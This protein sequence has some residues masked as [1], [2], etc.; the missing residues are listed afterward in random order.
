MKRRTRRL[1]VDRSNEYPEDGIKYLIEKMVMISDGDVINNNKEELLL[2]RDMR[3]SALILVLADTG[4]RVD[5][6]CRLKTGDID[7]NERQAIITSIGKKQNFIIRFSTRSIVAVRKYLHLRHPLDIG[8]GYKLSTLP[9]F[10]RHDR[11]LAGTKI[12]PVTTTTIRNING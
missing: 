5:E 2:L 9:V 7:W 12:K 1:K 4:L 8:T 6:V 11:E 3:D 10:A